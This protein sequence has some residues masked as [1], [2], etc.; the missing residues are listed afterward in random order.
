MLT[1]LIESG[2]TEELIM[3]YQQR[4]LF[5]ALDV[6]EAELSAIEMSKYYKLTC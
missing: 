1:L 3:Q 6:E 2:E 4:C 5:N